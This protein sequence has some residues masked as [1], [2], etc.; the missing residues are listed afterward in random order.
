MISSISILDGSTSIGLYFFHVKQTMERPAR[1]GTLWHI[2]MHIKHEQKSFLMMF[3]FMFYFLSWHKETFWLCHLLKRNRKQR[4][5]P[6]LVTHIREQRLS[7]VYSQ[8]SKGPFKSPGQNK[9]NFYFAMC[10]KAASHL[11]LETTADDLNRIDG[12]K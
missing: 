4:V 8:L 5:C 7:F 12:E 2:T 1:R 10:Q 3:E 6:L 9:T 11:F